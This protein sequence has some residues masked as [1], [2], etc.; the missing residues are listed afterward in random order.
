MLKLL[1]TLFRGAS[2]AAEEQFADRHALLLL[3][4]QLRDAAAAVERGKKALAI[5]I[6]QEEAEARRFADTQARIADLEERV[7][8]ALAAGRD[9]LATD[10]AEAIVSLETDRDAVAAARSTFGREIAVLRQEVANAS[11]RLAEADRGR[12]TAQAAE[13]VRRLRSGPGA[14]RVSATALADAEATLKRLRERQVQDAAADAALYRVDHE[15]APQSAA[16]RLEA[17][18]FGKRTRPTAAAVLDRLRQRNAT[19]PTTHA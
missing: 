17:E 19:G 16:D 8:A 9:D 5:A 4:Q 13:A 15:T 14:E 11:R 6:A 2:A 18:G 1:T 10:G 12:R 7:A 3:D